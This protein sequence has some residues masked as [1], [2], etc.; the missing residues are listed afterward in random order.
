MTAGNR[1]ALTAA[2]RQRAQ[3]T[4]RRAV[5]A[6]RRCDAAGEPVTFTGIAQAAD[7]SR[8]WLYRQPDLRAEID[9][10]RAP[11]A[12]TAVP[13]AQRASTDS[14]RRRLE[15]TLDEIQRLKAEN[16]QL[17]EQVARRFGQQRADGNT[18]NYRLRIL[19]RCRPLPSNPSQQQTHA[20]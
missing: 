17:R 13:S 16:R 10:V 8:S 5:E 20:A 6:L 2:A 4:R 3:D 11:S 18:D 14:M 9:R 19:Y 12:T 7:V 1:A 15:A